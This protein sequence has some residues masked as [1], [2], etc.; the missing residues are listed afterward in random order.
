MDARDYQVPADVSVVFL[1][2]PFAGEVLAAVLDFM[3]ADEGLL[4]GF[5]AAE[6]IDPKRVHA[7]RR[8]LPGATPEV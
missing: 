5:A 8:A 4:R 7:A 6:G 2:N 1:F 3:L